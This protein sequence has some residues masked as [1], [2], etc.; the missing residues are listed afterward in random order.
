MLV[1]EGEEV[2]GEVEEEVGEGVGEEVEGDNLITIEM[3]LE[4]GILMGKK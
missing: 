4:I 2:E 1:S 3:I